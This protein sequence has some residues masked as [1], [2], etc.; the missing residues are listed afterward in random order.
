M[1]QT[2]IPKLIEI[3]IRAAVIRMMR[4]MTGAVIP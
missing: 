1:G 3:I 2:D 4:A